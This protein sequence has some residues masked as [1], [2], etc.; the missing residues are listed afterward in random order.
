MGVEK[1][2]VMMVMISARSTVLDSLVNFPAV[3]F[4]K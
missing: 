4:L 3:Y 2:R 1:R